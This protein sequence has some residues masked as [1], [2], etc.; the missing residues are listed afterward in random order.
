MIKKA[1]HPTT[2]VMDEAA[3]LPKSEECLASVLPTGAYIIAIST[4]APGWFATQ[5]ER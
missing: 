5:C 4:A 3:F 1:F 2:Y